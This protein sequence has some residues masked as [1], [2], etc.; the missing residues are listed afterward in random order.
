M[1]AVVKKLKKLWNNIKHQTV[2]TDFIVVWRKFLKDYEAVIT[3]NKEAKK[4]LFELNME[5]SVNKVDREEQR[6]KAADGGVPIDD[7]LLRQ[8]FK[9]N[10]EAAAAKP[11]PW[12]QREWA[13]FKEKCEDAGIVGH[14]S[15]E[16]QELLR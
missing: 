10:N 7:T 4:I 14:L 8:T 13:E 6:A 3:E 16:E 5:M 1:K 12:E 15:E 11:K 9:A 2:L